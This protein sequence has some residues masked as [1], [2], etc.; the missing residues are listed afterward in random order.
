M[1]RWVEGPSQRYT[2]PRAADRVVVGLARACTQKESG[3]SR[4]HWKDFTL[5][6][7]ALDDALTGSA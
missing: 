7:A 2:R 4:K 1:R 3:W 5:S 6:A